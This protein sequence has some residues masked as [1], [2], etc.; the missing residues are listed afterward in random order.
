M[1]FRFLNG[2]DCPEWLLAEMAEFSHLSALKFKTLCVIASN[3]IIEGR[4]QMNE[5]ECSKYVTETFS[6]DEAIRLFFAIRLVMEKA[7]KAECVGEDL[8]KELQQLGVPFEHSKQIS[9]I[10]TTSRDQMR[11]KLLSTIRKEPSLFVDRVIEEKD[12]VHLEAI[13]TNGQKLRTNLSK[14]L[15]SHLLNELDAAQKRLEHLES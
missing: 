11:E 8:E 5:A 2:M 10:Y 14:N 4:T 3:S 15:Y 9:Q 13:A 1:R 12:T 7:S 6:R